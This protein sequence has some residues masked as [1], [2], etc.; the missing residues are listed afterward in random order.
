MIFLL[1]TFLIGLLNIL[2][3]GYKIKQ[4]EN[5]DHTYNLIF[6]AWLWSMVL[7]HQYQSQGYSIIKILSMIPLSA[8]LRWVYHDLGL[9]LIRGLAFDYLGENSALDIWL[10]NQTRNQFENKMI[11][12]AISLFLYLIPFFL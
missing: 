3:D 4:E 9:N 11:V 12:L 10:K 5:V 7:F 2:Y 8:A 6:V 1:S